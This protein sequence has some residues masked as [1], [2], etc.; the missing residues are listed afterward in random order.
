[1]TVTSES[2]EETE[3]AA[4]E[5]VVGVAPGDRAVVVG[6]TG[7]L[8]SGKTAFVKG[9][10]KALGVGEIVTSPTFVIEKIYKLDGQT[11]DHLIHIDAYRL[12][13]AHE[14]RAIGFE[15]IARKPKNLIFI[16]WPERVK[17]ILPPQMAMIEFEVVN[18]STRTIRIKK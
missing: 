10:A 5:F 13:G 9:V 7:E 8:G 15:E 3:Q 17:E 4:K 14:L 12:E 6:L 11:F 18:E 1:M 2:L 16:E